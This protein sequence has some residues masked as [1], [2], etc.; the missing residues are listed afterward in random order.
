MIKKLS[1]IEYIFSF[2]NK[3]Y[4]EMEVEQVI[5][6]KQR[7]GVSIGIIW[8]LISWIPYYTEYFSGFRSVIGI[9]AALGI[10]L[11]MG[12]NRGDAFVFSILLGA[13]IGFFTAT[14]IDSA[15]NGI[16]IIGLFPNS[17]K[18]RLPKRGY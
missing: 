1:D 5:S 4:Q 7:R 17:K 13:G 3:I 9:P 2:S 15:K 18:R 8:S 10:N 12:L 16:K 6:N 11:E 14:M